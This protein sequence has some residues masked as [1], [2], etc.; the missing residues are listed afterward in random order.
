M[1]LVVEVAWWG[2]K[3]IN[4]QTTHS[5]VWNHLI[6]VGS[7][8]IS[9]LR[10]VED[11]AAVCRRLKIYKPTIL[12]CWN[13]F[14]FVIFIFLGQSDDCVAICVEIQNSGSGKPLSWTDHSQHS[15]Q[16]QR[17]YVPHQR[18]LRRCVWCVPHW[19]TVVCFCLL[20]SAVVHDLQIPKGFRALFGIRII[21]VYRLQ[22]LIQS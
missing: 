22:I 18:W 15:F 9:A 4:N 2:F 1:Q 19:K 7:H 3:Y 8:L 13:V 21:F 16:L 11:N 5:T 12:R 14:F 17:Q 20:V 10:F 6:D